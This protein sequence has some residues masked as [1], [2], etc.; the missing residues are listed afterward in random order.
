MEAVKDNGAVENTEL[1]ESPEVQAMIEE[2]F[3]KIEVQA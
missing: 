2:L 1:T 3:E